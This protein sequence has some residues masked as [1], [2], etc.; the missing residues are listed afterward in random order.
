MSDEQNRVKSALEIA[1]EKAGKLGGLSKEEKRKL[2]AEELART[3]QVLA[4][5]YFD[6]LPQREMA[7]DLAKRSEEEREIIIQ[8]LKLRL[9]DEINIGYT[10]TYKRILS[11]IEETLKDPELAQKTG[12]LL[13]E[14]EGELNRLRHEN[15]SSLEATILRDLAQ[16]GISGSAVV[17]AIETSPDLINIKQGLTAKFKKRL[18]QLKLECSGPDS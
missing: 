4:Q 16:K 12:N 18:E 5:R 8:H 14:Y 10:A 13:R 9:L 17:P 3:A 1:L 6:G 2:R 7:E 11:A 15:Y